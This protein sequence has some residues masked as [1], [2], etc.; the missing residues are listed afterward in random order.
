MYH[1]NKIKEMKKFLERQQDRRW[2]RQ[3]IRTVCNFCGTRTLGTPCKEGCAGEKIQSW[4]DVL[5]MLEKD[6]S[7]KE[8]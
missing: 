6:L 1:I 3:G 2:S 8:D 4:I 5:D 7:K